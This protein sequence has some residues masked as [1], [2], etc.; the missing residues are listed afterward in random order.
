VRARVAAVCCK[1]QA[2]SRAGFKD[3]VW[4]PQG[5]LNHHL[6]A[7]G[8]DRGHHYRGRRQRRHQRHPPPKGPPAAAPAP[9]TMAASEG[10]TPASRFARTPARTKL[11]R[12]RLCTAPERSRVHRSPQACRSPPGYQNSHRAGGL[13]RKQR[14]GDQPL[15]LSLTGFRET[16]HCY[17]LS[18][19][20]IAAQNCIWPR[21]T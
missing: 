7:C 15:V 11:S 17:G 19:T 13:G 4:L 20:P 10:V 6:G 1:T 3:L 9:S 5:H 18:Q 12:T 8:C 16:S 2:R 14:A 21:T